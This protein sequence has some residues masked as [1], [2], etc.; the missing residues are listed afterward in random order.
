[1]LRSDTQHATR[2]QIILNEK[3]EDAVLRFLGVALL[4]VM[5]ALAWRIGSLLSSDAIGMAVGMALGVLAGVPAA[6]LVLLARRRDDEDE[7]EERWEDNDRQRQGQGYGY[8]PPIIVL[9]GAAGYPGMQGQQ[10]T[11]QAMLPPPQQASWPPERRERSFRIVGE[12]EQ[13]VE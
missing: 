9:T 13:Q 2:W 5:L 10:Q 3:G 6:A 8:Q 12:V 4:I 11:Q 7:D 1:V